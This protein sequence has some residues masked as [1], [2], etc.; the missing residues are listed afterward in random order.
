MTIF[1]TVVIHFD[2]ENSARYPDGRH[3]KATLDVLIDSQKQ[4]GDP[5]FGIDAIDEGGRPHYWRPAQGWKQAAPLG[6]SAVTPDDVF[7]GRRVF[8][9][10]AED[11]GMLGFGVIE[12]LT[13]VADAERVMCQFPTLSALTVRSALPA[14]RL[15]L[16]PDDIELNVLSAEGETLAS[17]DVTEIILSMSDEQILQLADGDPDKLPAELRDMLPVLPEGARIDLATSICDY[18]GTRPMRSLENG[19]LV[20]P[21]TIFRSALENTAQVRVQHAARRELL[22]Q[23]D[24]APSEAPP[25]TTP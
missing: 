23:R 13:K 14:E 6:A 19:E 2:P 20:V 9:A 1:Q 24:D 8:C 15:T 3:A 12:G 10:E 7:S 11:G 25:N 21:E 22:A 17:L 16:L 5:L 18:L 4:V